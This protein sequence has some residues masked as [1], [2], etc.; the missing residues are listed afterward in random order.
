MFKRPRVQKVQRE[1]RQKE[2]QARAE[3]E[4]KIVYRQTVEHRFYVRRN[5]GGIEKSVHA[6]DIR[7]YGNAQF[8]S[9]AEHRFAA[10]FV[11]DARPSAPV[12][13]A[14][15][16]GFVRIAEERTGNGEYRRKSRIRGEYRFQRPGFRNGNIEQCKITFEFRIAFKEKL[17]FK[18][19]DKAVPAD[20]LADEPAARGIVADIAIVERY[21]A[22]HGIG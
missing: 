22:P 2:A 3:A 8:D 4:I 18:T 10:H 14:V 9:I 11:V 7:K 13:H 6:D 15:D 19:G 17:F 16:I 21:A 1:L 5:G 20:A 12:E